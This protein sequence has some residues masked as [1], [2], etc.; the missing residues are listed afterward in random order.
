M[1]I[2]DDVVHVAFFMGAAHLHHCRRSIRVAANGADHPRPVDLRRQCRRNADQANRLAGSGKGFGQGQHVWVDA[3]VGAFHGEVGQVLRRPKATRHDQRIEVF[4]LGLADVLDLAPGNAR[5]FHQH[6][7]RLGH[8]F[9]GQVVDHMHLRNVR[10]EALHL[11]AALVQAQQGDHAF[12]N[13]GA[14]V[15]ATAGK[16]HRYFFSHL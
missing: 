9:A 6:V 12:V 4:G 16:N 1:G 15:H 14:V 3:A 13:F 2:F 10:R 8:L 5:R 11:R 7:A